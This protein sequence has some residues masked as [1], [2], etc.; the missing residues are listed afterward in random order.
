MSRGDS[1][2]GP[3]AS[4]AYAFLRTGNSWRGPPVSDWDA[5]ITSLRRR[6]VRRYPRSCSGDDPPAGS[7]PGIRERRDATSRS[8][9]PLIIHAK[10]PTTSDTGRPR[11]R[12]GP[13]GTSQATVPERSC[14]C[15]MEPRGPSRRN[16]RPRTVS[17]DAFGSQWRCPTTR[18]SGAYGGRRT[19][20][21]VGGLRLSAAGQ[22]ERASQAHGVDPAG[23]FLGE[24]V[25][26]PETPWKGPERTES[27]SALAATSSC[28]PARRGASRLVADR[29][30][31][32][33]AS[34]RRGGPRPIAT[35]HRA[36]TCRRDAQA[37]VSLYERRG[38]TWT[39]Q[40]RC[41]LHLR[42][43]PSSRRQARPVARLA[44]AERRTT[45]AGSVDRR[46]VFQV[47]DT[48]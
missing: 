37:S 31:P 8:Y 13:L 36:R 27:W 46:R 24:S 11:W 5:A 45:W 32:Y 14:V 9:R 44:L 29:S 7:A 40:A 4:K 42:T 43:R 19:G 18:R 22:P 48:A 30:S 34:A 10:A 20:A 6:R 47:A 23:G 16:S 35:A 25:S 33:D 41:W 12:H 39:E 3:S 26:A 38:T 17:R 21:D 1:A 2:A 15:A 28:A